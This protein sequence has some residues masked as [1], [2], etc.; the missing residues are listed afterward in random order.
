[1]HGGVASDFAEGGISK[2][3]AASPKAHDAQSFGFA[4]GCIRSASRTTH[5]CIVLGGRD[6]SHVGQVCNLRPI[7]N[8]LQSAWRGQPNGCD[9]FVAAPL[10]F[11]AERPRLRLTSWSGFRGISA[12]GEPTGG[13]P[14]K[15][16]RGVRRS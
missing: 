8:N 15:N 13:L 3:D 6:D 14:Y 16:R 9:I 10:R 1:M 2:R 7:C 12:S 5:T 4:A 11:G